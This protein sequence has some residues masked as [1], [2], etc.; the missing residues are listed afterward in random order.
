[1]SNKRSKTQKGGEEKA[2]CLGTSGLTAQPEGESP[3]FPFL[4]HISDQ[5]LE[6]LSAQNHQWVQTEKPP[7][8]LAKGPRK[9]QLSRANF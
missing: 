7:R 2:A 1:M 6:K 9:R 5:M 4:L 3:G 8:T